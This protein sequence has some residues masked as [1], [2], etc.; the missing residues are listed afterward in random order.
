MSF[1]DEAGAGARTTG[2]IGALALERP[3]EGDILPH[4]RTT[5]K[6]KTDRLDLLR[7]TQANLSPI[8]GLSLAPG[9]TDAARPAGRRPSATSTD[10]DGVRHQAVAHRR[11]RARRAAIAACGG[12]GAGGHRRR[13]P[14][15]RDL[16]SPTATRR[17]ELP[18]ARRPRICLV[19]ELVA[20]QLTVRRSTGSSPACPTVLDLAAAL[21]ATYDVRPGPGR[22]SPVASA[23][24]T[25]DGLVRPRAP[26]PTTVRLDTVRLDEA[27]AALP[28]H[29]LAFQ[30]GVDNVGAPWPRA[31]PTP[32]CCCGR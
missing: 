26:R 16:A 32:A 27:L 29:E 17:A 18:R 21:G 20:D 25:Q 8:W 13:P 6:A 31:G 4:E 11:S 7:A 2:V 1:T 23:L 9:L 28:E 24:V 14:P 3:G 22:S 5:P 30:H 15:L 10:A 12:R 19:V